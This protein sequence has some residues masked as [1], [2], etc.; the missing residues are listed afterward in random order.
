VLVLPPVLLVVV[1][2][3]D[4]SAPVPL[5]PLPGFV[6]SSPPHAAKTADVRETMAPK[7]NDRAMLM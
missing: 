3:D 4:G 5:P 1:L 7:R 2:D 6:A